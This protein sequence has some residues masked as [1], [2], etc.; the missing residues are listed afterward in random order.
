MLGGFS[1]ATSGEKDNYQANLTMNPVSYRI[2]LS[3]KTYLCNSRGNTMGVTVFKW[4][5][6]LVHEKEPVPETVSKVQNLRIVRSWAPGGKSHTII[7]LNQ[8]SNKMAPNDLL[9]QPWINTS[10]SLRRLLVGGNLYRASQLLTMQTW[11]EGLALNGLSHI[12]KPPPQGSWIY[13]EE[14]QKDCKSQA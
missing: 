8:H 6:D 12:S 4:I 1:R 7:L 10:L 11:G 14:G 3:E 9:V 2:E 5:W 13:E